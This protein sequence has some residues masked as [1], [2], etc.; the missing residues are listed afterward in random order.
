MKRAW[1]D[2]L[3]V[4]AR[5][6]RGIDEFRTTLEAQLPR[7]AVELRVVVPYDRGELVARLHRRAKVL[8]TAHIA[9]GTALHVRVDQALAAELAPYLSA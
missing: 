9:E 2:A 3:F 8:S 1:P 7:P 6:G 4:S 5:S